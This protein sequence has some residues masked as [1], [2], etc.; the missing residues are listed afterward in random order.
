MIGRRGQ[1]LAAIRVVLRD[2]IHQFDQF[3]INAN[4]LITVTASSEQIRAAPDEATVFFAP[5][6]PMVV[7]FDLIVYEFSSSMN[8]FRSF[9]M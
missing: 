5:F 4:R 9:S 8:S 1:F 2:F 3:F 7:G 6:D